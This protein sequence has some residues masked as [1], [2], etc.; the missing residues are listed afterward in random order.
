MKL[1]KIIT[2]FLTIAF[3][4]VFLMPIGGNANANTKT[5]PLIK[6]LLFMVNSI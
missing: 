1:K 6:S 4:T 2:S 5:N 3:C